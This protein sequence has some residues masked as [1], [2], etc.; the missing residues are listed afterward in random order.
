[1]HET[2]QPGS[3]VIDERVRLDPKQPESNVSISLPI[4]TS[5]A[6]PNQNL[7][8]TDRKSIGKPPSTLNTQFPSSIEIAVR[9][10][11]AS[12]KGDNSPRPD[13]RQSDRSD[14]QP[15]NAKSSMLVSSE[16]VS[17][18]TVESD[19]QSRKHSRQRRSTDDG[20]HIDDKLEHRMNARSSIQDSAASDSNVIV[21]SEQQS[22][23]HSLQRFSTDP[24]M[25]I[26]ERNKHHWNALAS[27]QQSREPDSKVTLE[28][29]EHGQK[30]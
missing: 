25:E 18:V 29:P 5:S 16:S 28:R 19:L 14:K 20:R 4:L 22:R 11:P 10:A 23:K 17:N 3:N 13:G 7:I 27:I 2:L 15:T 30:Q 24:G 12:A 9:S 21:E 1:M 26:D 6:V 8:E